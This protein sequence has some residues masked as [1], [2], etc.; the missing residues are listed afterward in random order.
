MYKNKAFDK[1][2]RNIDH[3]KAIIRNTAD[4]RQLQVD[5]Y[6]DIIYWKMAIN[7]MDG[8]PTYG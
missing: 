5:K 8:K 7:E 3:M 6:G 2:F 1:S 4:L